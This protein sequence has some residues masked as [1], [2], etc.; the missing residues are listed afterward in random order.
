MKLFGK[1]NNYVY[2]V[3]ANSANSLYLT[4][5]LSFVMVGISLIVCL[6]LGHV[7]SS[8]IGVLKFLF[9]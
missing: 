8:E 5:A 6:K 1:D 2:V 4:N 7:P 9:W 3:I